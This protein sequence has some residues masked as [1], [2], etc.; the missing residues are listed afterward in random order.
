MVFDDIRI[1]RIVVILRKFVRNRN[2]ASVTKAVSITQQRR[3]E[4]NIPENDVSKPISG[5]IA[6]AGGGT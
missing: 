2:A 6:G 3:T 4:K 5:M 1:F